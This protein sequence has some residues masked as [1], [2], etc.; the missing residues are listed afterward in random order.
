MH[1]SR[2]E[3]SQ[4]MQLIQDLIVRQGTQV[5]QQFMQL[6]KNFA[7]EKQEKENA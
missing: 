7:D 5:N 1:E 6:S 2:A 3:L 4:Q